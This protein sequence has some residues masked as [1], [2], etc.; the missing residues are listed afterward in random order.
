MDI[1]LLLLIFLLILF[2]IIVIFIVLGVFKNYEPPESSIESMQYEY[3]IPS[4]WSYTDP[5]DTTIKEGDQKSTN[6]VYG[7]DGLKNVYTFISNI[8]YTPPTFKFTDIITCSN[9]NSC[10]NGSC[11]CSTPTT[12]QTCID[13]DQ[14]FAQKLEHICYGFPEYINNENQIDECLQNNGLLVPIGTIE[15]F[16]SPCS[17]ES[18][19][20]NTT[21]QQSIGSVESIPDV[22]CFGS[23]SILIF[24][25]GSGVGST[26]F[27]NSQCFDS[28]SWSVSNGEYYN[29]ANIKSSECNTT[30]THNGYPSQLFR[31]Q[32][33]S[34]SGSFKQSQS[35][36][37]CRIVQRPSEYFLY[38][39]IE[40]GNTIPIKGSSIILTNTISVNET[41]CWFM[42]PAIPVNYYLINNEYIYTS[43]KQ[44]IIYVKNPNDI[45]QT[46]NYNDLVQYIITN[47]SLSIQ[48]QTYQSGQQFYM[49]DNGDL[50]LDNYL[51]YNNNESSNSLNNS[52]CFLGYINYLDYNIL[53]TLLKNPDDYTFY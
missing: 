32:R 49:Y 30:K 38:P 1:A 45:P 20:S 7:I 27:Q 3:Y 12:S 33:A 25:L 19:S 39:F 51:F 28:S 40:S 6:P 11:I 46:N 48:P 8:P 22:N 14:L 5:W 4:V 50:I 47:K 21:Q 36:S 53:P 13:S 29:I 2:I 18:K 10:A 41:Y 35:G 43:S 16:Y 44:Q 9:I 17:D 31:V 15:Q 37:F 23:I 34:Y 42:V 52:K 24:N 26:V